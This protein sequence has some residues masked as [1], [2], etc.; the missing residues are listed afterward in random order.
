MST[1]T[2]NAP[3]ARSL[4]DV[5]RY[6]KAVKQ[7][8]LEASPDLSCVNIMCEKVGEVCIC[9]CVLGCCENHPH[10]LCISPRD[11]T[12]FHLQPCIC[13]LG[14]SLSFAPN[15]ERVNLSSNGLEALP[16]ALFDL[17]HLKEL[18]LTGTRQIHKQ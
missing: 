13:K 5:A 9:V 18:D 17:P 10:H 3:A 14:V 16:D 4:K 8:V 12:Q 15:V 11:T 2:Y 7:L 1:L 6:H